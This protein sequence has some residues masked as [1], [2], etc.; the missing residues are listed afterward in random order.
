MRKL[1]ASLLTLTVLTGCSDERTVT[2][3]ND[4]GR[5]ALVYA[6]T[7]EGPRALDPEAM[8]LVRGA[9]VYESAEHVLA[10]PTSPDQA[11]HVAAVRRAYE[12]RSLRALESA[13]AAYGCAHGTPS[14]RPPRFPE[15]G[16]AA[17]E[18]VLSPLAVQGEPPGSPVRLS[19]HRG[20]T[21]VLVFWSSWCGPCRE[22][23][24]ELRSLVAQLPSSDV[25]LYPVLH[26]DTPE[27]LRKWQ[28]EHGTGVPFWVDPSGQAARDYNVRGVP[29]TFII[30]SDGRLRSAKPGYA[31]SGSLRAEIQQALASTPPAA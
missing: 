16:S 5:F 11:V 27:G 10:A 18:F 3:R 12:D 19:Q 21:V 23:Y 4:N 15:P 8:E 28:Q 14:R 22:E 1:L 13:V 26:M 9:V 7:T 29:W 25:A 6:C 20:R 30:G 2:L 24:E 17:P 31:G